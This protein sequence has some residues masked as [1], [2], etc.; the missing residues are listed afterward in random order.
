MY[1]ERT[2]PVLPE[3]AAAGRSARQPRRERLLLGGLDGRRS[4][5]S[6]SVSPDSVVPV[7]KA[8]DALLAACASRTTARRCSRRRCGP[9]RSPATRARRAWSPP[10][11]GSLDV[12]Q[13]ESAALGQVLRGLVA[14]AETFP[15]VRDVGPRP[16][17]SAA[18]PSCSTATRRARGCSGRCRGAPRACAP[19]SARGSPASPRR[20]TRCSASLPSAPTGRDAAAGAAA[21]RRA[22]GRGP[23]PPRPVVV[24]LRAEH[25]DGARGLPGLL[26]APGR[27]GVHGPGAGGKA[28][29]GLLRQGAGARR[30]LA[31]TGATS[32]RSRW[33]TTSRRSSAATFSGPAA[34]PTPPSASAARTSTARSPARCAPARWAT[35]PRPRRRSSNRCAS[36]AP[37]TSAGSSTPTR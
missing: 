30:R 23:G 1:D 9:V 11:S 14:G 32:S 3:G 31:R 17:R 7:G 27:D 34:T 4:S 25:G 12:E 33:S 6:P 8:L 22:P 5:A 35:R 16:R 19:R 13:A 28:R 29:R 36:A 20:S 2:E 18:P 10:C 37:T 15:E 21:D 24:A 26:G